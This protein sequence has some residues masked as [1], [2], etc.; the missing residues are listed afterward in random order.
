MPAPY[1][2]RV[3]VCFAHPSARCFI[4]CAAL[5]AGPLGAVSA[6]AQPPSPRPAFVGPFY[7]RQVPLDCA[8]LVYDPAMKRL[9]AAMPPAAGTQG[10]IVTVD[11]VTGIVGKPIPVA[12]TPGVIAASADGK[13]IYVALPAVGKICRIDVS[14]QK[15]GVPFSSGPGEPVEIRVSPSDA[16]RIAVVRRKP[17][18]AGA[19][20]VG[21]FDAGVERTGPRSFAATSIAFNADG[22]RLYGYDGSAPGSPLRRWKLDEGGWAAGEDAPGPLEARRV[23]LTITN[24]LLITTGGK[25][26]D[27]EKREVKGAFPDA[28]GVV[29]PEERAG[30]VLFLRTLNN[31]C[32]I[33]AYDPEKV[34]Q[35]GETAFPK[36]PGEPASPQLCGDVVAFRAGGRIVLL[37]PTPGLIDACKTRNWQ[38]AF[39]E[40]DGSVNV[41][42]QDE[43]GATAM[44]WAAFSGQTA[45]CTK[46]LEKR[47]DLKLKDAR[48]ATAL[49]FAVSSGNADLVELLLRKGADPNAG[50]FEGTPIKAA[51]DK[52]RPDLV[53][54]LQRFGGQ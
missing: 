45:L 9:Y 48:D 40:L 10:S 13:A 3:N 27:P 18:V 36:I 50:G 34:V 26:V 2:A 39:A 23:G 53:H 20:S 32:V 42:C 33:T 29:L 4:T 31:R 1:F 44:M 38:Q 22:T 43:S 14:A 5:L 54:L 7:V 37:G 21:L 24:G 6:P 47:A 28:G 15:A 30:R 51:T 8:D 35:I 46:L 17:G 52:R 41:D 16:E 25:V 11:P 49:H 19:A 12:G